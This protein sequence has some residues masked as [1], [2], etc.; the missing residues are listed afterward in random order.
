[1]HGE[2]KPE[3]I[4]EVHLLSLVVALIK[5]IKMYL[6]LLIFTCSNLLKYKDYIYN[7]SSRLQ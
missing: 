4:F 2:K 6:K 3:V 5:K 1:M 7:E